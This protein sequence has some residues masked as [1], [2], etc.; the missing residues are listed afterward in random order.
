MKFNILVKKVECW[1]CGQKKHFIV[2]S[3]NGMLCK[4]CYAK[5]TKFLYNILLDIFS[6]DPAKWDYSQD[7]LKTFR[8]QKILV[9]KKV[10]KSHY[11]ASQY[12]GE[13]LKDITNIIKSLQNQ[14]T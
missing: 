11:E 5:E 12:K 14:N 2:I 9:L 4:K 10:I 3:T 6:T 1:V 8:K 7:M 13:Y